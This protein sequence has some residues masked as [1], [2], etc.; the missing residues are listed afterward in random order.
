MPENFKGAAAR[1]G[2]GR[3]QNGISRGAMLG[4]LA[5]TALVFFVAGTRSDELLAT[6]GSRLG[7]TTQAGNIDFS[8]LDTTYTKLQSNFDGKLDTSK[9]I[10]GANKGMVAAAGD[11]YT[12]YMTKQESEEFENDLSG[13]IGGGI[14]AEIGLRNEIPTVVTVLADNPAEKAGLKAGDKIVAINDELAADWTVQEAV[15]KI[16]GESGT[17]VKLSVLRDDRETLD[18]TITRAEVNNPSVTSM[19]EDGIGILKISRF[20]GTRNETVGH[21]RQAA[22]KLKQSGVKGVILDLR[23]NGG[24]HVEA[25]EGVASLWLNDKLIM[26]ERAGGEIKKEYK[27]GSNALLADMPT[28]VLI[29]GSSASASEIV[30][31]AL[32]DHDKATLIGEKTFGKGTMQTILPLSR[33]ATLKVTIARWFTPSGVNISETGIKPDKEVELSVDNI[34]AGQDPQKDAAKQIIND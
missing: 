3:Y 14:G 29:N 9:L 34:N 15:G 33:G 6:F 13:D 30:A 21:A 8:S 16:R 1:R 19:I 12:A 18:F 28:A 31:G 27:S 4:V 7:I 10:D 17:T 11:P 5:V 22:I 20:D 23:G 2:R 26:T 25:A 24:G 32:K